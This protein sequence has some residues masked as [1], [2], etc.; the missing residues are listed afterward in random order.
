M[1]GLRFRGT[2]A[3]PPLPDGLGDADVGLALRRN[4]DAIRRQIEEHQ[5][6][7][8]GQPQTQEAATA[9]PNP[10]S[11][12][13]GS[14]PFPR[15]NPWQRTP[16]NPSNPLH[17]APGQPPFPGSSPIFAIPPNGT[18]PTSMPRDAAAQ[19]EMFRTRLPAIQ[20]QIALCEDQLNR[21]NAPSMEHIIR[22]RTHLFHHLDTQ[23][24][25]PLGPRDPVVESLLTRVFNVYTR[26]DQLRVIQS[27]S[28]QNQST[29]GNPPTAAPSDAPLHLLT[30]PDGHQ[31]LVAS[32]NVN[33]TLQASLA[34]LRAAQSP[35]TAPVPPGHVH[36]PGLQQN[37]EAAVLH[38][39]VRQAVL[40]QHLGNAQNAQ[41]GFARNLRR[42]W[43]FV[44]LYFFCY[45]FTEP[46][47]WARILMVCVA[48]VLSLLS[49]T[50]IPQQLYR[51]IVAPVRQ[52][53]E[54]LVQLGPANPQPEARAGAERNEQR[55]A[56]AAR[57]EGGDLRFNLRRIERS[58]ALFLASLI[59]GVGERHVQV[60]NEADA[61][62]RAREDEERRQEETRQQPQEDSAANDGP[63]GGQN[64]PAEHDSPYDTPGDEQP[65]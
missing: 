20:A 47:T 36:Q 52:H 34:A 42:I 15:P 12:Q 58:V 8:S 14:A 53:F 62:E 57:D 7:L 24:L 26:A 31:A 41:L 32:P 40:N 48:V 35:G 30:S 65:R 39:A 56:D 16:D 61:A 49:E 10:L 60:R 37:A 29:I 17:P 2:P 54:S 23:Y 3:P 28:A 19:S 13:I 33:E 18:A 21:G 55:G 5:R 38:N 22:I 51:M 27:R 4:I 63:E 1:S 6:A 46:G 64:A 59:P 44:R 11:S 45:M 50:G 43:L 9:F 25:N